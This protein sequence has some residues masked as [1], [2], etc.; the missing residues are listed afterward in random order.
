MH[1]V[2]QDAPSVTTQS[3]DPSQYPRTYRVSTRN[4]IFLVFVAVVNCVLGIVFGLLGMNYLGA[5]EEANGPWERVP[6]GI[7]GASL[8][9]LGLY[10]VALTLKTKV[11]L[12]PDRIEHYALRT[13]RSLR[14]EEIK[15]WRV[16]WWKYHSTLVLVPRKRELK[17]LHIIL[18]LKKDEAFDAWMAS[19]PNVDEV[20][21]AES[22]ARIVE[23]QSI[24]ATA[25]E[26][27]DLLAGA[28]NKAK[29]LNSI[30]GVAAVWGFFYPR[31][32]QVAMAVLGFVPLAAMALLATG[33]RL[34]QLGGRRNDARANLSLA[35]LLPGLVLGLRGLLDFNLLGWMP[36][37]KMIVAGTVLL[38][39]LL[40]AA[41]RG[42]IE[43]PWTIVPF[44]LVYL[45]GAITQA[46]TLL[47]HSKRQVFA[48]RVL[49]KRVSD[50][51]STSYYLRVEPWGPRG[52]ENEVEVS[53]SMYQAVSVGQ[54]ACVLLWPGALH[55]P[56]YVVRTCR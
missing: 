4:R 17:R 48:V 24:A 15:G 1:T 40:V 50:G 14:R 12:Y 35:F 21:R 43:R 6:F 42:M 47:D 32:Y 5:G 8:L 31:P 49:D 36:I 56:W 46:N 55:A 53:S 54:N 2:I 18:M 9:L 28:R 22:A 19:L 13:V 38:T 52:S 39:I 29:V 33:G 44:V 34:Y 10:I 25:E 26:R 27:S 11:I 41:S 51:K 16:V 37:I 45:F 30:A 20:E 3:F 23:D 7:L